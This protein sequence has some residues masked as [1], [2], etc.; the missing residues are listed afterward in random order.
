MKPI[1]IACSLNPKVYPG[2]RG[3]WKEKELLWRT[4]MGIRL[5]DFWMYTHLS[6]AIF[7]LVHLYS[8][9]LPTPGSL[10][11]STNVKEKLWKRGQCLWNSPR[12]FVNLVSLRLQRQIG[13][14][15]CCTWPRTSIDLHLQ[16]IQIRF[17]DLLMVSW[18]SMKGSVRYQQVYTW[19]KS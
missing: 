14:N 1:C 8:Q 9:L 7:F 2:W 19:P 12:S 15:A 13:P 4:S 18:K 3:W 6:H 16:R 11:K 17:K 10:K 5:R